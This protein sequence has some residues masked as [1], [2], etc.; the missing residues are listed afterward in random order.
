VV[1]AVP[2]AVALLCFNR[3]LIASLYHYGA[4]TARD[5]EQTAWAVGGYG[6]GLVGLV[7]IKVLAP[8]FYA[9]QNIKTP[10]KIAVVVLLFT[11]LMNVMLVPWLAH[12]GLALS[13]AVGAMLNA[14]LL[15]LGLKRLKL[16]RPQPGWW[17]LCVQVLAASCLL[18]A[19]LLGASDW[20]NWVGLSTEK[21]KR[22]SLMAL[23]VTSSV[24]IYFISLWAGG[25]PLKSL[26]R[27]QW[28]G[29]STR[30]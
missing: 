1:L 30:P 5:V 24:A 14:L 23:C 7:A 2:C 11:Q 10:V 22:I 4:F 6:I 17:R 18:A 3:P 19:F 9:S 8:G 25:L 29:P 13:I 21:F 28:D 27:P 12:A 16:Y 26:L 15:L 20:T